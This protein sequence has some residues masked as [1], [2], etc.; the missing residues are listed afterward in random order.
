MRFHIIT[1][2]FLLST[3]ALAQTS[4]PDSVPLKTQKY[5]GYGLPNTK[6]KKVKIDLTKKKPKDQN[7]EPSVSAPLITV[8]KYTNGQPSVT[9]PATKPVPPT[10]FF[11]Y[12]GGYD[13]SYNKQ[14][15]KQPDGTQAEYLA[16]EFTPRLVLGDFTILGDFI[17]ADYLDTPS[18]SEWIDSPIFLSRAPFELGKAVTLGTN[19]FVLFPLSKDSREVVNM[20]S[21]VGA[22]I[23]L[24]MNSKNLGVEQWVL[25][26]QLRYTK[27]NNEFNTKVDGNPVTAYQ[28]KQRINLAYNFTDAFSFK[29]RFEY[30]SNYS[31]Q[32]IV[33][34][35][36]IHYQVFNYQFTDH[37][38]GNFGLSAGGNVY[39]IHET[40]SKA[41]IENDLKF[42]DPKSSE[43]A[44]GLG[45]SI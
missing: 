32:N 12:G 8:P 45:F 14:A 20:K 11:S 21:A 4:Q 9:A 41:Y 28:I 23:T 13:F 27:M 40:D 26:Y 17:Y 42:Y 43:L 6:F 10:P 44:V 36:Y 34:N 22:G 15:Q 31:S 39:S 18:K 16:H 24:G 5:N 37:F 3:L 30:N 7:V 29:T 25:S 1:F 35:N 38:S 19:I 2:T 33:R